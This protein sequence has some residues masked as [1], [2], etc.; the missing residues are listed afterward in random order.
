MCRSEIGQKDS[1]HVRS[2]RVQT[3]LRSCGSSFIYDGTFSGQR[4]ASFGVTAALLAEHGIEVFAQ[5]EIDKLAHALS[6]DVS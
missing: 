1:A 4:H 5:T 6:R 3:S 2:E